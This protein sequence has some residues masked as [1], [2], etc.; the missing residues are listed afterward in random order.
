[1]AGE[2][3]IKKP[4][5]LKRL[6]ISNNTLYRGLKKGKYPQPVKNSDRSVAWVV[7]EIDAVIAK[8]MSDRDKD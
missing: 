8:M 6:R 2:E 1:M 4:E 5:V 7:S 3:L